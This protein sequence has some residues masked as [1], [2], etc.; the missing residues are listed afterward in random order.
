MKKTQLGALWILILFGMDYSISQL[1]GF[2]LLYERLHDLPVM[3]KFYA[4][5]IGISAFYS[6]LLCQKEDQL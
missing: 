3:G 4:F 6:I 2:S 5:L 1:L